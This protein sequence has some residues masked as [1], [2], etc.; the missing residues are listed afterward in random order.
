MV[1]RRNIYLEVFVKHIFEIGVDLA[2]GNIVV[3]LEVC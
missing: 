2:F 1:Y 3:F